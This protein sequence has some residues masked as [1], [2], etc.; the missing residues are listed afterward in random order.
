M[1]KV[2]YCD[3]DGVVADFFKEENAVQ[4]CFYERNF[5]VNLQPI[6][7]NINAINKLIAKGYKITILSK[8]KDERTDK[9]KSIW[10][11][12][13]MPQITNI[14]FTRDNN[15]KKYV[16]TSGILFDDYGKNIDSW[17]IGIDNIGC[18]ITQETN[19]EYWV[20][21]LNL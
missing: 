19:I 14:I 8:S 17:E 21:V 4:R 10:L 1:K 11:S 2:I 18:Q 3:M 6:E 15:K 9:E 16:S 12:K 5:F 20:K 13:Y 7:N